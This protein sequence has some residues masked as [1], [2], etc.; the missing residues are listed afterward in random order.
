[1]DV[2]F[3]NAIAAIIVVECYI[4]HC[5]LAHAFSSVNKHMLTGY[6]QH[7]ESL[8]IDESFNSQYLVNI[9]TTYLRP[10]A[11]MSSKFSKFYNEIEG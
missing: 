2:N 6:Y 10:F 4:I 11:C 5:R 3:V 8:P 1:M 9:L 7:A